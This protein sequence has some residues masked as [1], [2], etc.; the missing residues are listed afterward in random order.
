VIGTPLDGAYP[1]LAWAQAVDLLLSEDENRPPRMHVP[2]QVHGDTVEA[3]LVS[4]EGRDGECDGVIVTL[5]TEKSLAEQQEAIVG[6]ANE[7]RTPMTS[8]R[9]YTDLLL[10]EQVGIL[11]EMQRQFLERVKA[12]VEHMGQ[13]LND[14]LRITSPDVR[15][16]ELAPQPIDLI[17]II[18]QAIMGLSARFR[19]RGLTV[20][21]DLPAELPPVRADR[22][23]LYQIMLRLLSNAALCSEEG[24]GVVVSAEQE[25]P[26]GEG[27]IPFVRIAVTDTGGGI[28]KDDIPK[29]FRRFFRAR[30]PLIEGMG[31]RGVGMAV[32]KTL[33]EANG[34][35][36]WVETEP[37]EGSTFT[38]VLPAYVEAKAE[39]EVETV[40]A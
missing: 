38:F 24:S 23:S 15:E 32:A 17:G 1:N 14:L 16:I 18:E 2:L 40:A 29:V 20:Q 25:E 7:F 10:G 11:T 3:D 27:E 9:G 8:I 33:V 39:A 5:R 30:Q 22:D 13:M 21:L 34:G 6:I 37:G 35:R 19:E 36:I 12:G 26:G 28:A 4:L 31:E